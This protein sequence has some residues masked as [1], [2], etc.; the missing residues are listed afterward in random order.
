MVKT[1]L[2]LLLI[3]LSFGA[4]LNKRRRIQDK[5]KICFI[6]L[7]DETS[8][9]DGNFIEAAKDVCQEKGVEAVLKT[10]IPES[11]ECYNIA[12]DLAKSGCKAIFA[13]SF[14]HE[15]HLLKAAKEFPEIQFGHATGTLAHTSNLT[16]F[17]NTFASIYEGRYVTGIAAG[18]KLN[19]MIDKKEIDKSQA[20]VGYVGAFP[21]AEVISGY[22]AFYLGVK[23]VCDSAIMKVRYTN[24]WY[25]P[26]KEKEA[27]EKLIDEDKCKI[28]SQHADSDGVPTVC[29]NKGIPNVFYNSENLNL[30][31]SYLISSR[32][33]WRP[34]FRYFIDNTLSKT[35]ME[36]DWTGH[37]KDGAV[38]VYNASS[39]AAEGT[40]DA[41]DQAI[42]DLKTGKINVF[43]TS[44]FTVDGKTLTSYKADVNTDPDSKKDT[45]VISNGIF[46]ESHFRSSPYF[47][48][49][50]DGIEEIKDKDDKDQVK[51][52]PIRINKKGLNGGSIAGIV[53]A[54]VATVFSVGGIVGYTLFAT[55][56]KSS[57]ANYDSSSLNK[58]VKI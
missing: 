23:S 21:Y 19:E 14:G 9:Y 34:Y 15:E 11:D 29:E 8:S 13:D 54:T 47:D 45:E 42:D 12:K 1:I 36:P 51:R 28:I 20:I 53:L 50:I 38:E 48:I 6:F 52:V 16:N 56:A 32:I 43:D 57:P 33:N 26:D 40:Q 10:N 58:L 35:I 46:Q 37:L 18:M 49:I 5:D 4:N 24:S 30:T 55:A 39:L 31:K 41:V 17:H 7:H 27:A 22:T 3:E 25:D 44:K 2:V